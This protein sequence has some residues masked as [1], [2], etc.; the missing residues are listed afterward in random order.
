MAAGLSTLI[1]SLQIVPA[2]LVLGA[3]NITFPVVPTLDRA[4]A[5]ISPYAESTSKALLAIVVVRIVA[6]AVA[7]AGSVLGA[8]NDN[9]RLHAIVST[10]SFATVA[11]ISLLLGSAVVTLELVATAASV[12]D[13]AAALGLGVEFGANF[14]A[15]EAAAAVLS[16]VGTVY[17][18]SVWFVEFRQVSFARRPR[19]QR[20]V[21]D[22]YGV[23]AE[24]KRDWRGDVARRSTRNGSPDEE[25]LV[26]RPAK[27]D[28]YM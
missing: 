14:V 24:L 28:R 9:I 25:V 23:W 8:V 13:V 18:A 27:G 7:L 26:D 21:G 20:D 16:L 6:T 3:L 11:N 19:R 1:K 17:W 2:S 10:L 4:V 12:G 22:W 5:D 15:V